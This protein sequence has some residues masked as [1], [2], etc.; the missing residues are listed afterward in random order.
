MIENFGV[1][2]VVG[3]SYKIKNLEGERKNEKTEKMG[4]RI[5]GHVV[6]YVISTTDDDCGIGSR[7]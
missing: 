7:G 6:R 2:V 4:N 1:A 3:I 5:C